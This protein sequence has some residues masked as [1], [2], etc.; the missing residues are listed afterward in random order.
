MLM[1]VQS[2]FWTC[3]GQRVTVTEHSSRAVLPVA[4]Y[5][6]CML[7]I[8]CLTVFVTSAANRTA[9]NCLKP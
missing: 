8:L 4:G 1:L 9:C 3:V 2:L 5:S 7:H 6:F